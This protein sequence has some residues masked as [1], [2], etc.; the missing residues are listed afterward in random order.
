MLLQSP[1]V[2]SAPN[3]TVIL[4]RPMDEAVPKTETPEAVKEV[5]QAEHARP[6]TTSKE[7]GQYVDVRA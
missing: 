5:A 3:P 2:S 1:G 7:R 4:S 6:E